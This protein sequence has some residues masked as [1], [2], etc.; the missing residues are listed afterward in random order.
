MILTHEKG[1]T[2]DMLE[3]FIPGL[4]KMTDPSY[5]PFP[6]VGDRRFW[7]APG[8]GIRDTFL[9]FAEQHRGDEYPVL[10]AGKYMGFH[11][12]GNRS[13]YQELYFN[14]RVGLHSLVAAELMENAD[15]NLDAI[16][17]LLWMLC[18]E[19][20][21][22]IPA[23]NSLSGY[24]MHANPLPRAA[25]PT[26]DLMSA[27]T[28]ASM[29]IAACT[30]KTKLDRVSPIL[31]Q[32]VR[33][34]I[35]KRILDPYLHHTDYWWMGFLN[36]PDAVMNNW[37]PWINSNVLLCILFL[38]EDPF[39]RTELLSKVMR[40]L[41][42]YLDSVPDDGGCDEGPAYWQR[43]GASAFECLFLLH[44][45]SGGAIDIFRH[46][47][48]RNMGS[49]IRHAH[50]KGTRFINY[51]DAPSSSHPSGVLIHRIGKA[52]GDTDLMAFGTHMLKTSDPKEVLF[53]LL[54]FSRILHEV[55]GH[56]ETASCDRQYIPGHG[57]YLPDIQV[58]T[59]RRKDWFFSAKGGNN[60]ENHNHND[61]GSFLVYL[62]ET[63]VILDVGNMAYTK[64]TF[65]PERYE[66]WV[67][68][69]G[70]HNLPMVNGF[71]QKNGRGYR[72]VGTVYREDG[73]FSMDISQAYPGEAGILSWKRRFIPD[74]EAT[75]IKVLDEFSLREDSLVEWVLMSLQKPMIQGNHMELFHEG[76]GIRIIFPPGLEASTQRI[77]LDDVILVKNYGREIYR[78][79][80]RTKDR[81]SNG[82]FAMDITRMKE[83]VRP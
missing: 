18:E 46:Q 41:D 28:A 72:A 36:T 61:V 9:R 19:T 62:G 48:I 83:E 1:R 17:D 35:Q 69:S 43:A 27:E 81:I 21:W 77:P 20:T 52:T 45:A 37:N 5:V 31:F 39:R 73:E 13:I 14:R 54:G 32:R 56:E 33:E 7:E 24:H 42:R 65:S 6:P 38:E 2:T 51:A 68:Q 59:A 40:S 34:E 49:Y 76:A 4:G 78:T 66:I 29:A 47:K 58:L 60:G 25:H 11:R 50:I 44:G 67:N 70:F 63:P 64:K 10:T 26:I 71:M 8:P 53:S 30:L 79:I 80:A 3:Q 74:T 22:V 75:G 57:I 12:D 23:H 82:S 15:K 55:L 16:I